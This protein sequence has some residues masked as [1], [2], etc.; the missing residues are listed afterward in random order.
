[1][2]MYG[3]QAFR[4]LCGDGQLASFRMCPAGLSALFGR[5]GICS[6]QPCS[7]GSQVGGLPGLWVWCQAGNKSHAQQWLARPIPFGHLLALKWTLPSAG[8]GHHLPG[9]M[10]SC[11]PE[12]RRDGWLLEGAKLMMLGPSVPSVPSYMITV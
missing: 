6:P 11:K 1:M 5:T 8:G 10:L 9:A 3:W 4:E 12:L 2:A 7:P